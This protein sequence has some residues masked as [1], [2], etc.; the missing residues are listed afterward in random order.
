MVPLIISS[1]FKVALPKYLVDLGPSYIEIAN[2]NTN[3]IISARFSLE[4][5]PSVGLTWTAGFSHTKCAGSLP[6]GS[7][8]NR[9]YYPDSTT[10]WTTNNVVI[11]GV[12]NEGSKVQPFTT[13]EHYLLF[14]ANAKTWSSTA[15]VMKAHITVNAGSAP[16]INS[17]IIEA[18][19]RAC[20][21]S[22]GLQDITGS[23][24]VTQL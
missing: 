12:P 14:N 15:H 21:G 18:Y 1:P 9:W 24:S 22:F 4:V 8:V 13:G 6:I 7:I 5:D 19:T 11:S 2:E 17:C 3:W 16:V 10:T 20:G 23:V